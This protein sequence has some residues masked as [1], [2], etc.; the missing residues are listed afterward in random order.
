M[1]SKDRQLLMHWSQ[2]GLR[3]FAV[4]CRTRH[5]YQ[6]RFSVCSVFLYCCSPANMPCCKA[7][8]IGLDVQQ[9]TSIAMLILEVDQSMRNQ[10]QNHHQARQ[11]FKLGCHFIYNVDIPQTVQLQVVLLLVYVSLLSSMA[12]EEKWRQ[13]G[14]SILWKRWWVEKG[15]IHLLSLYLWVNEVWKTQFYVA[16]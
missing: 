5:T 10:L 4:L 14:P 9:H 15:A 13:L 1:L 11:H 2:Q 3:K 7:G 16:V 6:L 8:F 12:I